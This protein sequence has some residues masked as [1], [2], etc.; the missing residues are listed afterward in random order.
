MP[1]CNEMINDSNGEWAVLFGRDQ[2]LKRASIAD[3][4][5]KAN[6]RAAMALPLEQS[7]IDL[8]VFA[9]GVDC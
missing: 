9:V 1:L 4:P 8:R 5:E 2:P 3:R 7:V 6:S